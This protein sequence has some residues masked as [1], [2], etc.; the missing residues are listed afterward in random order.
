ME[1]LRQHGVTTFVRVACY[2]SLETLNRPWGRGEESE[3]LKHTPD[4]KEQK[5][6]HVTASVI[7][8]LFGAGVMTTATL[9]RKERVSAFGIKI[10]EE[11]REKEEMNSV[12]SLILVVLFVLSFLCFVLFLLI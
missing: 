5:S 3:L 8:S 10:G 12:S 4:S 11:K 6:A 1:R 2:S 9:I 7:T